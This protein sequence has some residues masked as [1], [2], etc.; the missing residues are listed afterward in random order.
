MVARIRRASLALPV[1]LLLR[2]RQPAVLGLRPSPRRRRPPV[3]PDASRRHL[4]D[5]DAGAYAICEAEQHGGAEGERE[6][7]EI[8]LKNFGNPIGGQNSW[9]P[10]VPGNQTLRD[11]SLN[12]GKRS[13]TT[14]YA[15]RSPTLPRS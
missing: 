10:L 12:R 1:H 8:Q 11:G 4:L 9:Y 13:C 7:Q 2:Q 14:S 15:S 6:R 3:H 5:A